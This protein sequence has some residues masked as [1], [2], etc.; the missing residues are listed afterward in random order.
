MEY[1]L[2]DFEVG[3]LGIVGVRFD[4][5]VAQKNPTSE[6]PVDMCTLNV[7]FQTYKTTLIPLTNRPGD[8]NAP[9]SGSTCC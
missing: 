5:E 1:T 3:G 8:R 6:F 4:V 9:Q 2:H 7:I